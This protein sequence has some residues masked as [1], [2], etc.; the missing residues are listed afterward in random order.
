V[1]LISASNLSVRFGATTLFSDVTFTVA[2]GE[3]WAI[4]GRNGSGKTTLFRLLAGTAEPTTGTVTTQPGLRLSVM[5]QHRDFGDTATI[6][7]AAAGGRAD[8]LALEKSLADQSVEIGKLAERSTPAMLARY[9]RDLEA[10]QREGG[11]ELAPKV[12]AVLHGLGFD[13]DSARER[14]CPS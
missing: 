10:F 6:W 4:I 9:D 3:R 5:E 14:R 13:P 11:Y 1:T 7:E 2:K 8:L 12:D